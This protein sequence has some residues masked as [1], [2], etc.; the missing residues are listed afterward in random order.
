[1]TEQSP[2]R[3]VTTRAMGYIR[4]IQEGDA[5]VWTLFGSEG[6][7]LHR[8]TMRSAPFFA[9]AGAGIEIRMLN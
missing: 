6:E 8:S 1:M 2:P 3:P 9:A 5:I 7:V 4:P